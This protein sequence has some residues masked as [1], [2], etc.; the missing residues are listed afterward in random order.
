LRLSLSLCNHKRDATNDTFLSD[1]EAARGEL[2]PVDLLRPYVADERLLAANV[3]FAQLAG[4]RHRI[5]SGIQFSHNELEESG[6]YLDSDTEEAYVSM[7]RKNAYEFGVYL[8]DEF[9]LTDKLEVVAGLRFDHHS[10]QDEF[11]GSGD[12]L[13]QGLEPLEYNESTINPRFS[14]RC[15]ATEALTL[16]GSIGSGYRVPYGFSEDLH[17]CSG[18]PRVYKGGTLRPEKSLSY[19]VTADYTRR[20]LNASL[21]LYRTELQNA[22]AF[23]DADDQ[24]ADLGYTYQWQNIDNAFVMGAEF[25]ASYALARDLTMG[26]RFDLFHGEY[27]NAREDWQGS[28]YEEVSKNISRFPQT[29]GGLKLDYSPSPWELVIDADYKGKMYIDLTEP[30][31][32]AD[33]K[34]HETESFVILNAKLSKNLFNRYEVYI[35]ARNLTDYTQEEKHIDDAAF[36]YAPVYGRIIYGGVQVAL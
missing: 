17:L 32:P 12:V 35:G 33:I 30:A 25:N 20:S 34:I 10:S 29:S 7:S 27:D 11:R 13:P 19:S 6:M 24:V 14:I 4:G 8:Q 2:P 23:A 36:M 22:I 18:S 5:L 31:N 9:K 28:P 26:L 15:A 1:Y 16:R 3:S 21:N